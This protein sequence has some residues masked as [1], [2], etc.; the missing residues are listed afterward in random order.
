MAIRHGLHL[1]YAGEDA[2][3]DIVF[4]H[5][6]FGHCE[7]TWTWRGTTGKDAP[8]PGSQTGSDAL[9]LDSSPG[10]K[11]KRKFWLFGSKERRR[12]TQ[13]NDES[14]AP[15]THPSTSNGLSHQ[16]NA[17]VFWPKTLLPKAIPQSRVYSWGYD[18]DI[19]HFFSSASQS[20]VFQHAGSLLSDLADNR[21]SDDDKSRP[22]I[23]VA[24]SLGGI[25][26]K[27][28][29]NASRAEVTYL[30]EILPATYGVIFLGTPHRG[31]STAT[32]GKI[33]QNITRVVRSNP[34]T[35]I[36]QD[37]EV[38]SETLERIGRGFHQ[39]LAESP[40]QIQS[41]REELPTSGIMVVNHFSS[42]I[43]HGLEV[44][45]SIPANHRDMVKFSSD[46]DIGFVRVEA[47]L[48]R[49]VG[50]VTAQ[51]RRSSQKDMGT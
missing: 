2:K 29:L 13:Q 42:T 30:K 47:V 21:I 32:L 37:L 17:S 9:G 43:E 4:V 45:S 46:S 5:G 12:E 27:D 36:L 31:S 15:H 3:V 34:N 22:I 35:S 49:W 41:F 33:A 19:S 23:F 20:T 38:N 50:S 40:I 28:M 10:Q 16:K 24:H 26:V 25:V 11:T 44:V 18:A 8:I 7:E 51:K 48:K 14:G 6:L 1:L 39:I